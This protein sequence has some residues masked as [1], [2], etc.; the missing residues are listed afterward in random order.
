MHAM[1]AISRAFYARWWRAS[2]AYTTHN[3]FSYLLYNWLDNRLEGTTPVTESVYFI[4]AGLKVWQTAG[5]TRKCLYARNNQ[6]SIGLYN[7]F[8]N[9]NTNTFLFNQPVI[10]RIGL[11]AICGCYC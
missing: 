5:P 4:T 9:R 7:R 10:S 2:S 6:L 1:S 8:D 11:T 3:W